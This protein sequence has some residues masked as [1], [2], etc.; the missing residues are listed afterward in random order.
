MPTTSQAAA[1]F[2]EQAHDDLSAVVVPADVGDRPRGGATEPRSTFDFESGMA[3]PQPPLVAHAH[4][5]PDLRI[6]RAEFVGK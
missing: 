4:A 3:G 2:D 1:V 5:T 6:S